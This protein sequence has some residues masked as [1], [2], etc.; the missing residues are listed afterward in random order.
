MDLSNIKMVV[1]DMDGTLLN[2]SHEVSPL[3]FELFEELRK[4]DILFVAA[5]G[6]QHSSIVNKLHPIKDD[7]VVIAE[8]GGFMM[9]REQELLATPLDRDTLSKL[10]KIVSQIEGAY[11]VFCG[12]NDAFL[13][14]DSEHFIEMLKQYY[15]EFT[16]VEDLMDYHGEILKIAVYHFINS[17]QHIYP[18]VMHLEDEL[19]VKVSG[20]NWVDLSHKNANKGFAVKKLQEENNI[21]PNETLV[22]G[23]YNNDLEMLGRAHFSFA[24]ANAH[25]NVLKAANYR[26]LSNDEFGVEKVLEQLLSHKS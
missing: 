13:K 21:H 2:S 18:A 24:M 8:N 20:E 3:F 9:Q 12:K 7:I 1:T 10:L 23:D 22:F 25:P 11:P 15:S 26:T 19:K 14:G 5:S 17:E 16:L 4:R 6:R